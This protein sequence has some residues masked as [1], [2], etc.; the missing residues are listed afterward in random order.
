MKTFEILLLLKICYN[1]TIL[2]H[3]KD[4]VM[5]IK[6]TKKVNL[7][8][9]KNIFLEIGFIIALASVLFAFEWKTAAQEMTP[10]S[11]T[12]G[13]VIDEEIVPITQSMNSYTPPPPPK[14]VLDLIEVTDDKITMEDEPVIID[15]PTEN[16]RPVYVPTAGEG[17]DYD[18]TQLEEDYFVAVQYMPKFPD[19]NPL[20]WIAKHIKYPAMAQENGIYGRV[21]LSFIIEKDGSI[22]D[23]KVLKGVESSLDKE[24][25]RVVGSMPKWNPG[26]QQNKTVRVQYTLPIN[27]A[28]QNR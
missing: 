27:F 5:E 16:P 21:L 18:P 14:I 20:A 24:A 11:I 10:F 1:F 4:F 22:T 17:D 25:V 13:D 19:G 8:G 15:E 3:S 26:R 7:E 12:T 23:I 28:L 6:K 9:R 2:N